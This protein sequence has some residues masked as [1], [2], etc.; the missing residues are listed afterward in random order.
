MNYTEVAS[1]FSEAIESAWY[2]SKQVHGRHPQ[3][4][5]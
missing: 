3:E 4:D 5:G 2:R 1:A